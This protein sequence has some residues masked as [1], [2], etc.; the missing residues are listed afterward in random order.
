MILG[1]AA[2]MSPEQAKGR[3]ADKR[4][5]VW[6]FGVV[7]FEM[8][9]G[10]RAFEGEDVSDTLA[11]VLR[12][13][14]DWRAL[15]AD[16]PMAIHRLLRRCLK[17]EPRERLR[18]IGD[19]RIEI[20]DAL[21]PTSVADP[22]GVTSTAA[23]AS[24]RRSANQLVLA[25]L[26]GAVL[27]LAS[28]GIV[29][30]STPSAAA[31]ATVRFNI[32]AEAGTRLSFSGEGPAAI[33]QFAMS[34]NGRWL[35]FTAN[36]DEGATLLWIRDLES[37][38]AKPLRRTEGAAYPFW[39]PDSRWIAFS[40][41]GQLKQIDPAGEAVQVLCCDSPQVT[42]RVSGQGSWNRAGDI[43]V[44]GAETGILRLTAAT[45]VSRRSLAVVIPPA[46]GLRYM[47]PE[48][49]PDG[50]H[51]F[52]V[53][54]GSP[55][56]AG[57]YLGALDGSA[58]KR[59]LP[60]S[61]RAAYLSGRMLFVRNNV[62][63]A[64]SFDEARLELSG[65]TVTVGDCEASVWGYAGFSASNT[66]VLAYST[67]ELESTRLTWVD[68]SGRS[69]SSIGDRGPYLFPRLSPTGRQMAFDRWDGQ[70]DAR[71][72]WVMDTRDG[73]SSR[74]TFDPYHAMN[75]TWSP[76]E[77]TIY[78][79]SDRPDGGIF[80]KSASGN[81]SEELVTR[82]AQSAYP[83]SVSFDGRFLL[84]A[85]T[86]QDFDLWAVPLRDHDHKPFPVV[87]SPGFQSQAALS[88]VAQLLAYASDESGRPEVYVQGFPR[89]GRRWQV[90]S[91]GGVQPWWR[92]D[93]RE[94]YFVRPDGTLMAVPVTPGADFQARS[95][96]ALFPT[97][98]R[99][100]MGGRAR[101]MPSPDGQRFLM[102][103]SSTL[104]LAITVVLNWTAGIKK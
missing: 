17:K 73:K 80:Q 19:A 6:A 2:Y 28:I 51:F 86:G 81:A 25:A 95:P 72:V 7:L 76:D 74:L 85:T 33:P 97:S 96:V 63:V 9:T 40:A 87:V 103:E 56:S 18:D 64:Q 90:S 57:L 16:L 4:S 42:A 99:T 91:G 94:L 37:T 92:H 93:G 55:E 79:G 104:P 78:Y 10:T 101:Y 21:A 45:A 31:D 58:P 41:L 26:V 67:G 89:A 46:T 65:N 82:T 35:A 23:R 54:A 49:L 27:A 66:G 39:S 77:R 52:F 100:E 70:R 14:P 53:A 68:R 75:P 48:F 44:G 102:T 32:V 50:R 61:S 29:R 3:A 13:E 69:L 22:G 30:V 36:G 84:Y 60:D 47:S 62:L 88:P 98:I 38:G 5:D 1:T 15:P 20:T 59:L 8:L 71:D 12:G 34:P 24:W 11:A 83:R 43:V